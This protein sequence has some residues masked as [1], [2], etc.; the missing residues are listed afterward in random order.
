MVKDGQLL[1]VQKVFKKLHIVN[2][3]IFLLDRLISSSA[4]TGST[5]V[6]VKYIN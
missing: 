2:F 1:L 6:I 3:L 5:K 4:K